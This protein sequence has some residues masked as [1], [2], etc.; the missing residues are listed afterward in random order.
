MPVP[1]GFRAEVDEAVRSR[2]PGKLALLGQEAKGAPWEAEGAALVARADGE[3][4]RY[5]FGDLYST[6]SGG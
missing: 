3:A 6:V 1:R 4:R 5:R 2:Q